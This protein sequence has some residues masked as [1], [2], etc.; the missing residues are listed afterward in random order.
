MKPS[1]TVDIGTTSVKLGLFDEVGGLVHAAKLPTPTQPDAHGSVYDMPVLLGA[2]ESFL[3]SLKPE[4][5]G[6]LERIA[7]CGVGESGALVDADCNLLS[8]MILWHDQRGAPWINKLS[9]AE[10]A[11]IYAVTGLPAHGNYGIS[12]VAW[13]FERFGAKDAM[14]LNISEYLAAYLTKERWSE[15]SL[16]SRTMALDL[17]TRRWSND[18]CRMFGLTVDVFPTLRAATEGVPI[19]SDVA[20]RLGLSPN[21]H[22]HVAGHDHMVGAYGANLS[23][24]QLL[25]STGTT[26]GLLLL[27]DHPDLG[28][29]AAQRKVSGGI[30]CDGQHATSFASIPTAGAMFAFLKNFLGWDQERLSGALADLTAEYETGRINLARVPLV[31]PHL[32]GSPPPAKMS[33]ARGVISGL[34]V[35]TTAG[36]LIFGCFLAMAADMR[37]VLDLFDVEPS[38]FRV[39][40]PASS[41]PLW[42]H[43]KADI[44][45]RDISVSA[46]PEMVS[47]GAQAL[48]SGETGDWDRAN[49]W[50]VQADPERHAILTDWFNGSD[51]IHHALSNAQ[52]GG[53]N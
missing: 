51:S 39:I 2:V 10:R 41:N 18:V 13:A 17:S 25:N 53:I 19:A 49:P 20:S 28:E 36:D 38:E 26:E 32:R 42:L 15:Y 33:S 22:V 6:S 37:R 31:V 16:A 29:Q 12:K 4:H 30:S 34:G 24:S 43:L 50:I 11:R 52:V 48:A 3:A 40:G 8:P 35:D 7:F 9:D 44:L 47:M 5:R 14:W 45:G 21:V 23:S 1:L 27:R 46:F